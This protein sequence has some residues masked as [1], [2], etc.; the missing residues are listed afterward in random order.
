MCICFLDLFKGTAF[1]WACSKYHVSQNMKKVYNPSGG[2][3]ARYVA[4]NGTCIT[5]FNLQTTHEKQLIFQLRHWDSHQLCASCHADEGI[6]SEFKSGSLGPQGPWSFLPPCAAF[7]A[8]ISLASGKCS[9]CHSFLDFASEVLGNNSTA[10][11]T[12]DFWWN[13][14]LA[15]LN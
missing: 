14:L 1:L 7:S 9:L 4:R 13:D 2:T 11:P 5:T 3:P 6:D 12:C 8:P 10:T 15:A